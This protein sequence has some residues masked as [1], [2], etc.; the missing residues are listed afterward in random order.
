MMLHFHAFVWKKSLTTSDW[1][2]VMIF[3]D[4][5]K[6]SV[7]L[8][9]NK[10]ARLWLRWKSCNFYLCNYRK[11]IWKRRIE[12]NQIFDWL[13]NNLWPKITIIWF[14]IFH[15]ILKSKLKEEENY[16]E[17][18]QVLTSLNNEY[19]LKSNRLKKKKKRNKIENSCFNSTF[20]FLLERNKKRKRR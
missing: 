13:F 14:N 11:N 12:G 3:R 8:F 9:S 1:P 17:E 15:V 18:Q 20:Q 5:K 7:L 6:P 16:I 10:F 19:L 4:W 2:R